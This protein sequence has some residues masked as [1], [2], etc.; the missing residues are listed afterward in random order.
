MADALGIL[1]GRIADPHLDRGKAHLKK[2]GNLL[3]QRVVWLEAERQT[4]D[5]SADFFCCAA[6]QAINRLAKQFALQVPKREINASQGNNTARAET[7]GL[8]LLSLDAFPNAFT[9]ERIGADNQRTDALFDDFR[10]G[11]EVLAVMGLA[12]ADGAHLNEHKVAL[13]VAPE[14]HADHIL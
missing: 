1:L 3:F 2:P 6:E 14:P 12:V 9:V 7:M 11:G 10:H 8:N 13:D 4:A 5:I